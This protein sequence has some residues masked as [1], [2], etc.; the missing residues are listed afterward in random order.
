[1]TA[2]VYTRFLLADER[3]VD[4]YNSMKAPFSSVISLKSHS[5]PSI[6]Y[7]KVP[8][9]YHAF[10]RSEGFHNF[11]SVPSM[12]PTAMFGSTAGTTRLGSLLS[13]LPPVNIQSGNNECF[14]RFSQLP[15]ELQRMVWRYAANDP[16][17]RHHLLQ[18]IH[19][20]NA[21]YDYSRASGNLWCSQR[22]V[23]PLLHACRES[24][25]VA[26]LIY[27]PCREVYKYVRDSTWW[28]IHHGHRRP[29]EQE[30]IFRYYKSQGTRIRYIHFGVD[31]VVHFPLDLSRDPVWAFLG[32][33]NHEYNFETDDL[34]K[35][36]NFE[37]V[38][39]NDTHIRHV[40]AWMNRNFKGA[41]NVTFTMIW[42]GRDGHGFNS[43]LSLLLLQAARPKN[44]L[45]QFILQGKFRNANFSYRF[46]TSTDNSESLDL[47]PVAATL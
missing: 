36:R 22:S 14:L 37:L 47:V 38:D 2:H 45:K 16:Q 15:L 4:Q 35:F 30:C 1:M 21:R 23:P 40:A 28:N 8:P 25:A 17:P 26:L 46:K 44:L 39:V 41:A 27:T 20:D 3:V 29:D 34:Q 13:R 6:T 9:S 7:C 32:N 43:D 11:M 18:S 10:S 24:R 42:H 33:R 31:V 12:A 5:T 19:H